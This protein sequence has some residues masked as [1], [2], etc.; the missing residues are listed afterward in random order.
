MMC[1]FFFYEEKL[2]KSEIRGGGVHRDMT[3]TLTVRVL[4]T[5]S[6]EVG[7]LSSS[8]L[9]TFAV[10]STFPLMETV[11]YTNI[12]KSTINLRDRLRGSATFTDI[13]LQVL[14]AYLDFF[15]PRLYVV[16]QQD[17]HFKH[18]PLYNGGWSLNYQEKW[19][20]ALN[21]KITMQSSLCTSCIPNHAC[22]ISPLFIHYA[23]KENS[24]I[25]HCGIGDV[26]IPD[27]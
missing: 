1:C 27:I 17:F 10:L 15:R 11:A 21:L 12:T 24:S 9:Q 18:L 5:P 20:E 4:L 25:L 3:V 23:I 19:L 16:K 13:I 7:S 2:R 14:Q 8:L 22:L 26:T 6:E